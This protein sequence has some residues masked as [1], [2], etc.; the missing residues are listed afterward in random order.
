MPEP[1]APGKTVLVARVPLDAVTFEPSA[2]SSSP[3]TGRL[4]VLARVE[5][6]KADVVH[7]AAQTYDLT[8]RPGQTDA[9]GSILFFTEAALPLERPV[10]RGRRLRRAWPERQR[11]H[12][13]ARRLGRQ[14]GD[15]RV[16]DLIVANQMRPRQACKRRTSTASGIPFG[17]VVLRSKSG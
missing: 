8:A 10:S 16:G 6:K 3:P 7:Y 17:D 5:N 11:A 1:D 13:N 12:D 15:L 2:A 9:G 14:V 4:T